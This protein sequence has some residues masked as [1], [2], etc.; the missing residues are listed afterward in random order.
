MLYIWLIF[1]LIFLALAVYHLV[2]AFSRVPHI[3]SKGKVKAINGI[4]VGL[5]E[6]VQD[7]NGYIDGLNRRSLVVNL[8]TAAGYTA[9][10]LTA[11]FSFWLMLPTST[12]VSNDWNQSQEE[13][14]DLYLD[15]ATQSHREATESLGDPAFTAYVFN[16]LDKQCPFYTPSGAGYRDCLW[17]VV[18]AAEASYTK[19]SPTP[20]E[21][22]EQ[23][24]TAAA[25]LDGLVSGEVIL[26][27]RAFMLS[28]NSHE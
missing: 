28:Q 3:E 5:G 27:C 18:N 14:N 17:E 15:V 4:P 21:I 11:A 9:A 26:S 10:A 20:T 7:F 22:E 12:A 1:T 19:T 6:F 25:H 16:T 2:Q 24:Q 8:V 13:M 23:C